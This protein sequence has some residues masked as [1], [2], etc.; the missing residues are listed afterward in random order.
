MSADS[1]KNNFDILR[2]LAAFMVLSGHM[3]YLSGT[4][5][6]TLFNKGIQA[7]GVAIFFLLGGYLITKSWLGDPNPVRYAVKRF[8]RIWPPLAA[9]T[10]IAA[11]LIGPML[12]TLPAKTYFLHPQTWNF[13]KNLAFYVEYALPGVFET[14]PYPVAVNGS[15]WTLPAEVAMYILIPLFFSLF[16]RLLKMKKLGKTVLAVT[17]ASLCILASILPEYRPGLRAV[18]YATNWVDVLYVVPWYFI[19][20]LFAVF[21]LRKWMNLQVAIALVAV[22]ASFNFSSAASSFVWFLVL[23][24]LVFSFAFAPEPFFA[25]FF[26]KYEI[27]YGV[28]LYGFFI[29]QIVMRT[30]TASGIILN[31]V[32]LMTICFSLTAVVALI[33]VMLIERPAQKFSKRLLAKIPSNSEGKKLKSEQG[34]R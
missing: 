26:S 2:L 29:Q 28:Y 24:Y 34:K 30:L 12:T 13:L 17:T 23:P 32:L 19:G 15:L 9:F 27:S 8:F 14:N 7:I 10:L 21:D 6:C 5:P 20:M 33:S 16:Y 31:H 3:S 25:G 11:F 4:A 18:W 1:R 22:Y